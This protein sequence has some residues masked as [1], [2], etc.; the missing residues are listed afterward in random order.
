MFAPFLPFVTEEVWSWWQDGSV[1]RAPWPSADEIRTA[2]GAAP[3]DAEV[4]HVAAVV[5]REVRKAKSEANLPLRAT[6]RS[7]SVSAPA[8]QA[9]LVEQVVADLREAG[10]TE[11]LVVDGGGGSTLTVSVDLDGAT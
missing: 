5:L 2:A 11:E 9:A 8:A 1:H 3:G 4:L 10:V 6:A 7:V